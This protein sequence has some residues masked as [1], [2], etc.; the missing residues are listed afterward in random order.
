MDD[1][2]RGVEFG[3]GI[4][5]VQSHYGPTVP[6]YLAARLQGPGGIGKVFRMRLQPIGEVAAGIR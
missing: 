2:S 3:D 5:S 1:R 6:K 4:F